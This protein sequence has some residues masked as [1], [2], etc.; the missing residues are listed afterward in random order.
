M[1][2]YMHICTC[3]MYRSWRVME[4]HTSCELQDSRHNS[5]SKSYCVCPN[6]HYW[7]WQK[8][9]MNKIFAIFPSDMNEYRVS[10]ILL[11]RLFKMREPPD[12]LPKLQQM[13]WKQQLNTNVITKLQTHQYKNY[14]YKWLYWA[15]T[16]YFR[17]HLK[18]L[19]SMKITV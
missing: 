7:E 16:Q 8:I 3:N 9:T 2:L 1:Y 12:S 5:L 15:M 10:Q 4:I 6:M 17:S 13:C 11:N 19:L 14:G 18:A